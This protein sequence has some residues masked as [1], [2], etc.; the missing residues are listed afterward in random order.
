M[1]NS[2]NRSPR[3][4]GDSY[5]LPPRKGTGSGRSSQGG[6]VGQR[7][8]TPPP[9]S[10]SGYSDAGHYDRYRSASPRSGYN[11]PNRARTAAQ[12]RAI[13]QRKRRNKAIL[14]T[15]ISLVS[16]VIILG[17]VAILYVGSIF[18]KI[19]FATTEDMT[20][21]E[22]L[23]SIVLSDV[24]EGEQVEAEELTEEELAALRAGLSKDS[25]S[26][27][28]LFRQKGVL[29][30]LLLGL[31]DRTGS[32]KKCRSDAIIL[33]SVNDHTKQI[34]MTSF[35]RDSYVHIP[36]R[37]SADRIN[38]ANAYGGPALA[39]KTIESNFG[40][41]IDKFVSMDFYAF[42]DVVDALG[43]VTLDVSEAERLVMNDYIEVINSDT[44]VKDINS[45]KLWKSGDGILVTGKQALGYVRNRYTGNGDFKRTERQREVLD[46]I[47]AKVK[48]SNATT[49]LEVV[50]A[51]AGHMSTDFTRSELL[52]LATNVLDYKDYEVVQNRLPINDSWEYAT[53]NGMS[54]IQM[55]LEPNRR[56]LIDTI[57]GL[58]Q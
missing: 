36:G 47:I 53:I 21:P 57:Y 4:G 56:N 29:N 52:G 30:V 51:A 42:I 49:L 38:A 11:S 40:V 48:E 41:D 24:D 44:G 45:G 5:Y 23:N 32:G 27:D 46:L 17:N 18:D 15:F 13:A 33:L 10:R 28:E 25:F 3:H 55:Q 50:D 9:R 6:Y 54:I 19:D 35:M 7:S 34:V 14:I 20:I 58:N 43:G 22:D 26:E 2:N 8:S 37:D 16:L 1:S 31:D 39:I 12:R